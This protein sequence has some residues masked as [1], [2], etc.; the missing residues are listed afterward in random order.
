MVVFV[1]CL[2][3]V[4]FAA[5]ESSI[6]YDFI[7]LKK[8]INE[9][10]VKVVGKIVA[11]PSGYTVQSARTTGRILTVLKREGE[12]VK[13][14]DKIFQVNSPDCLNVK[15]RAIDK[16][17]DGE[18]DDFDK[19]TALRMKNLDIIVQADGCYI[20]ADRSGVIVKRGVEVGSGFNLS[21]SLVTIVDPKKLS[22]ELEITEVDSLK[23]K[24]GNTVYLHFQ[25]DG[26]APIQS[27]ITRMVPIIDPVTRVSK[28]IV[29][30]LPHSQFF[31]LETLVKAE[32]AIQGSEEVYNIPRTA[33]AFYKALYWVV[34]KSDKD[35]IPVKVR[36]RSEM[37]GNSLVQSVEPGALKEGDQI[38]GKGAIFALKNTLVKG[39]HDEVSH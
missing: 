23:I 5:S 1:C 2:G 37:E 26:T 13:K 24:P 8:S 25:E 7:T 20:V 31:P 22:A 17:G 39:M 15:N 33:L 29:E 12:A 14:G 38:V 9:N 36:I 3:A 19:V 10:R 28:A 27:K 32:I 35:L 16:D 4:S 6:N 34:K 11:T 21:D 30:D 18:I